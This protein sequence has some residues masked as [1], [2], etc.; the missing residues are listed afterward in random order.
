MGDQEAALQT[1][2]QFAEN[3]NN[4]VNAVPG[5]GHA[6]SAIHAACGDAR[7]ATRA[8]KMASSLGTA[9]VGEEEGLH[10][11]Q[12]PDHAPSADEHA[13]PDGNV[14]PNAPVQR[15]RGSRLQRSSSAPPRTAGEPIRSDGFEEQTLDPRKILFTHGSIN[16]KFE[17]RE[18]GPCFSLDESINRCAQGDMNFADF[19]PM[20]CVEYQGDLWSLSNRRLFVA[21]A[22]VRKGVIGEVTVRVYDMGHP[23][24]QAKKYCARLLRDA[25]WWDRSF[26]TT[27]GGATPELRGRGGG[28]TRQRAAKARRREAADLSGYESPEL[29]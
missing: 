14:E 29:W 6:K 22:L 8:F 7:G 13:Q 19:P 26:T 3:A 25:S 21:Q 11:G 27:N 9:R 18:D 2:L 17:K 12:W 15:A 28:A 23:L 10:F 24:I 20:V 5:V 16:S 4:T 1:Q